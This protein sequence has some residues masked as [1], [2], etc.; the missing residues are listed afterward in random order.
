MA[1]ITPRILDLDKAFESLATW[2]VQTAQDSSGLVVGLSG[3]DSGLTYLICSRAAQ[4]AG[5]EK[6]WVQGI[7]YGEQFAFADWFRQYG[8]VEVIDLPKN[9]VLDEDTYRWAAIGSYGIQHNLW[10]VGSRTRTEQTLGDY[11][12]ASRIAV[13]QPVVGLWKSEV[14]DLVEKL[15][16]PKNLVA[17][18]W[19][20]DP[21][22]TC[23]RPGLMGR[24]NAV[25]TV[26]A[27]R[28]GEI[29][30]EG[31]EREGWYVDAVNFIDNIFVPGK[32]FKAKIPY[33]PSH[34]VLQEA[35]TP[36][37]L[38]TTSP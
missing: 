22:C 11:S 33:V 15:E 18:G 24:L 10:V 38:Y 19:L 32:E 5:K 14:M 27:A 37:P 26:L 25:E 7:H 21:R 28:A 1:T 35:I 4:I 17:A 30:L 12:N 29:D 36:H 6:G 23:H 8:A 3:T 34:A 13:M 20:G 9:T 31:R 2:V 16:M